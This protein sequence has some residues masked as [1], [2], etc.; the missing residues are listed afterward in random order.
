MLIRKPVPNAQKCW[1]G[2]GY[3]SPPQH[4]PRQSCTTHPKLCTTKFTRQLYE[5]PSVGCFPLFLDFFRISA[6]PLSRFGN[7]VTEATMLHTKAVATQDTAGWLTTC[8]LE[9]SSQMC[10]IGNSYPK[11][12][13][14][15]GINADS[16]NWT[17]D[18]WVNWTMHQPFLWSSSPKLVCERENRKFLRASAWKS[19]NFSTEC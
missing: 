13:E 18:W 7:E 14:E 5:R 19:M 16:G 12:A 10:R 3:P 9:E 15:A 1:G 8:G 17:Y 2:G 6:D 4:F 11:G